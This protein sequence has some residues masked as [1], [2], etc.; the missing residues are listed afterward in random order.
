MLLNWSDRL[1]A[2]GFVVAWFVVS[3]A[4]YFLLV[5]ALRALTWRAERRR[6]EEARYPRRHRV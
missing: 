6:R 5:G 3:V 4:S 1:V 2:M